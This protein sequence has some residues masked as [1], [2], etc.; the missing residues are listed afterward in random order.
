MTLCSWKKN[1]ESDNTEKTLLFDIY[2]LEVWINGALHISWNHFFSSVSQVLLKFQFLLIVAPVICF[3][4]SFTS[5]SC[6][7]EFLKIIA[8]SR[9]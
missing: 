6:Q 1:L 2:Y 3:L 9:K 5:K 4:W 7:V 8:V